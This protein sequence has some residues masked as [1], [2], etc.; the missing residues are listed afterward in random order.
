MVCKVRK[1][2]LYLE[3][4]PSWSGVSRACR[5]TNQSQKSSLSAPG[6]GRCGGA[7]WA[8]EHWTPLLINLNL[9]NVG[10]CPTGRAR[11]GLGR[12]GGMSDA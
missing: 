5:G 6:A 1:R 2:A 3:R 8:V 10:C 12:F 4:W 9:K 11:G 7:E